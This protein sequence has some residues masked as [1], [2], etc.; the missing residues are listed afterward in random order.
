MFVLLVVFYP[1]LEAA[2]RS[3]G[4]LRWASPSGMSWQVGPRD[5]SSF[6]LLFIHFYMRNERTCRLEIPSSHWVSSP[7]TD[8][9]F[10]LWPLY[11][12]TM[13]LAKSVLRPVSPIERWTK[14]ASTRMAASCAL[15]IIFFPFINITGYSSTTSLKDS[16]R[17]IKFPVW[18]IWD[19]QTF[20]WAVSHVVHKL[21]LLSPVESRLLLN[22]TSWTR[23]NKFGR[24]EKTENTLV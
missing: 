6:Q 12:S 5:L 24:V 9:K 17:R 7:P 22:K 19:E 23:R 14:L 20:S 8:S 11:R 18:I 10:N 4:L 1:L 16:T 15:E 21:I 2:C 13:A 3:L